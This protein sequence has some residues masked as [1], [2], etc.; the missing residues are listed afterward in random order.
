MIR[1]LKWMG[2]LLCTGALWGCAT[3]PLPP[4]APVDHLLH[5]SAFTASAQT[6]D[7]DAALRLT[8]VMR[9]YLSDQIAPRQ[10]RLPGREALIDALYER[11]A[12]QL[13]YDPST[14]RTA[15]EAFD[16]RAGNCL[17]LVLMTAAFA[18]EMGLPVQ[19]QAVQV[20]ED[21]GRDGDLLMFVGHVNIALG[22]LPAASRMSGLVHNWMT[23]DFLPSA[24]LLRQISTPIDEQRV[25]AMYLNNKAAE[26]LSQGHLDS[27]YWW[28]RGAVRQD[29]RFASAINTLAVIYLRRGQPAWAEAALRRSLGEDPD[30]PHVLNNLAQALVQ[31]DRPDEAQPLAQRAQLLLSNTPYGLYERGL[32]A[33]RLGQLEQAEQLLRRA[34][35][36]GDDHHEFHHALAQVLALRGQGDAAARELELAGA[37][38]GTP[39]QRTLYAGKLQRLREQMVH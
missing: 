5:D 4:A 19:F 2:S 23:V 16:A 36:A 3:P 14:T 12:L 7:A 25:V 18:R 28:A 39:R 8:P 30:N 26:A 22:N 32:R 29:R 24:D 33:L 11:S 13:K 38:A 15:A 35:R 20:N 17:S 21:W 34:L 31:L 1:A 10:I 9:Q 6:V 27:A 37:S